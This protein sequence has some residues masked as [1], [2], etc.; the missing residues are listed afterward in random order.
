MEE[1]GEHALQ[2]SVSGIFSLT[3][4]KQLYSELFLAM[5]EIESEKAHNMKKISECAICNCYFKKF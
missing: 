1:F 3:R 2:V 5:L 4:R